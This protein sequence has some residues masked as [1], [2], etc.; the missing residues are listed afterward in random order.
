[1]DSEI[2]ALELLSSG[3]K[4][5]INRLGGRIQS[6]SLNSKNVLMSSGVQTGSTFWPSPQSLW[7]WPPPKVI[8]QALYDIVKRS[9]QCISLRSVVD[10]QHGVRVVKR[11][12]PI[13][14]GV[15]I[16]YSII[17]ESSEIITMAPWEISRVA[18]GLTFYSADSGPEPQSTCPIDYAADHYWYKYDAKELQ[19][20]P[21]IFANNTDGWLANVNDGLLFLKLFPCVDPAEIAPSEAEVEIYAHADAKQP[22]IELEQQGPFKA[23]MPGMKTNWSVDWLLFDVPDNIPVKI[24]SFELLDFVEEAFRVSENVVT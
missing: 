12:T 21:K 8:D 15:T 2:A 10:E 16:E 18:G 14:N 6:F 9:S 24:G 1:M 4:I 13:K 20:I 11:I 7:G 22:Y 5:S 17:N 19:G 23:I 3:R